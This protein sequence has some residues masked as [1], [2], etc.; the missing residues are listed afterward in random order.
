M[1]IFGPECSAKKPAAEWNARTI[2]LSCK[3]SLELMA[4]AASS[5]LDVIAAD[6][7]RACLLGAALPLASLPADLGASRLASVELRNSSARFR[8]ALASS[9]SVPPASV[10]ITHDSLPFLCLRPHRARRL[11]RRP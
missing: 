6:A 2:T 3:L 9:A 10:H 4:A 7:V 1:Q 11:R 8:I 5:V